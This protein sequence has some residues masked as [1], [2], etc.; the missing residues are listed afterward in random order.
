M[1]LQTTDPAI[2]GL[3]KEEANRQ[4]EVLEMIP[5][6]NYSST[7]VREAI[8]SVLTNKYSEGYPHKRYYQGNQFIDE[9]EDLAIG[10]AKKLF[11][12]PHV[13]VQPYSGSPANS[14]VYFGLLEPGD[15]I[16]GLKLSGGGHLTHGHPAVTF[17]GKYFRSVQYDV[18]EEG[19]ID[20]EYVAR[21][22]EKEKPKIIVVG[23]TAYPRI[24]DWKAWRQIADSVGA[25]FLA[26]IS[27]IVGLIVGGVHPSPVPYADVIMTTTHKTLR[28]PRGAI[29]MVTGRGLVKDPAM[30]EK[31]DKA[32]FPGLQGGPHDN[33]TAGIAVALKEAATPAF[34]RYAKQVVRNARVL[35]NTLL[36]QGLALSTGGTDNHLMV[37]DLRPQGVIGNIV[38]EALEVAGIVVNRNSVPHDPNPPF[39][40]SGIR[41][42][43]PAI[44]TRGMGEKEMRQIGTWIGQVIREVS[45]YRLPEQK[46]KRGTYLSKVR[47]ELVKNTIFL[48][49]A[50]EVRTLCKRFPV[51]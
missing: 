1:K 42:G 22:A 33:V 15:T 27:H 21:L 39:Y 24:Y 7:A 29:L 45:H 36:G 37:V 2:A 9:A 25:L 10:R 23:T 17:S 50:K 30:G 14:A 51:P 12:V 31:I 11:G 38:A 47:R 46:E 43:T 35:A 48:A 44:T 18:T 20:L 34:K 40:P 28:G 49:I 4:R 19:I 41:L 8:G 3:I 5:S 13:N 6:E 32:V 26:D 16:M